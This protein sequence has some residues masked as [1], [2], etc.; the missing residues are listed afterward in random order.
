M[1]NN[2]LWIWYQ[3]YKDVTDKKNHPRARA[4][5]FDLFKFV[6]KRDGEPAIMNLVDKGEPIRDLKPI[7]RLP[8]PLAQALDDIRHDWFLG[9]NPDQSCDEFLDADDDESISVY[10]WQRVKD[11]FRD[12]PKLARDF[13]LNMSA[14]DY[15]DENG[16]LKTELTK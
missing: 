6:Y 5:S 13:G 2:E 7:S 8:A 14:R 4:M 9:N 10:Y 11:K 3:I 1:T 12:F 15:F 16:N